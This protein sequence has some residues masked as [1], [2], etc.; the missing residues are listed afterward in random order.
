MTAS[1]FN[2]RGIPSDVMDLLKK[3]AKRL[4]ISVNTLVIKM[5]ERG[6][7]LTHKRITHHDLDHL[8]GSWSA[9]EEKEFKENTQSFEQIDKELWQ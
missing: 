5:I 1:N 4:H 2:L 7:G 8:A 6:L 9:Q 3:E